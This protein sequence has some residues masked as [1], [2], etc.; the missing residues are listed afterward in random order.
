MILCVSNYSAASLKNMLFV[1]ELNTEQ[2]S[3]RKGIH[4]DKRSA[5]INSWLLHAYKEIRVKVWSTTS[6]TVGVDILG[7]PIPCEGVLSL[8]EHSSR[9]YW[10]AISP[11][12]ASAF[13]PLRKTGF[14]SCSSPSLN[15]GVWTEPSETA[16]SETLST[17]NDSSPYIHLTWVFVLLN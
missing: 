10:D 13:Y 1:L 8:E 12:S 3:T 6:E 4:T 11:A 9:C 7:Y 17:V 5:L 14:F 16:T 2:Q 15:I